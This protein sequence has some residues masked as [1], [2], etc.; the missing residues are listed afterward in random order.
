MSL[1]LLILLELFLTT[2]LAPSLGAV[3][4]PYS[5]RTDVVPSRNIRTMKI[6]KR[7]FPTTEVCTS[8]AS[9][10]PVEAQ[11]L[12]PDVS[13]DFPS[14][15]ATGLDVQG[16]KVPRSQGDFKNNN[17]SVSSGKPGGSCQLCAKLGT[18]YM[19][20]VLASLS[21]SLSL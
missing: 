1:Q 15:P 7:T 5:T 4:G 2:P 21:L 13:R 18:V 3:A 8:P 11:P 20:I 19:Y 16:G 17:S 9:T 12:A 14:L 6:W 10:C